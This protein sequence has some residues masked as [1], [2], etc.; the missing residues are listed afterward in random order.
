M[1]IRTCLLLAVLR[2]LAVPTPGVAAGQADGVDGLG[3]PN[4]S[5]AQDAL[6]GE[7]VNVGLNIAE[8]VRA[9]ATLHNALGAAVGVPEQIQERLLNRETITA[10][11]GIPQEAR[12][13][14]QE[15]TALGAA[16]AAVVAQIGQD[17]PTH[18]VPVMGAVEIPAELREQV[19]AALTATE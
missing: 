19:M 2:V 12:E 5:E 7:V 10:A 9:G 11:I 13:R 14:L 18:R 15:Q 1:M 17:Y 3:R 8:Q 6:V 4:W 16:A